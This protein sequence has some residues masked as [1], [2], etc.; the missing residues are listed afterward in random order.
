MVAQCAGWY[1]MVACFVLGEEQQ[2]LDCLPK[3]VES[4]GL[5][6][7]FIESDV[8]PQKASAKITVL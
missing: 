1:W 7:P 2:C 5:T 6:H 4:N 8:K 3:W